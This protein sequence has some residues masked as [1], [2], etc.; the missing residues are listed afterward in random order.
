MATLITMPWS[1]PASVLAGS[2]ALATTA[3]GGAGG[4]RHC[5]A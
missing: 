4:V 5:A 1:S 3:C 2:I